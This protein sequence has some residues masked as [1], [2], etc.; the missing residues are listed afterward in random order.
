M[1]HEPLSI[2][3]RIIKELIDFETKTVN[4]L[5][6]LKNE[7][8]LPLKTNLKPSYHARIFYKIEVSLL[9]II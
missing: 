7:L 5:C 2:R 1:S 6:T 8:L 4:R 9:V 3:D